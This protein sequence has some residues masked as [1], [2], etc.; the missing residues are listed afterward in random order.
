M[1]RL[2]VLLW[3]MLAGL[4]LVSC[5]G[6]SV[7]SWTRAMSQ[8]NAGE[9]EKALARATKLV[10]A[11]I[12]HMDGALASNL[13]TSR[14]FDPER[15]AEDI[16]KLSRKIHDN[17]DLANSLAARGF[18]FCVIG[19]YNLGVA[20]FEQAMKA[21]EEPD[22]MMLEP[23]TSGTLHFC[24]AMALWQ[25][26]EKSQALSELESLTEKDEKCH[27]AWFY[28]GVIRDELGQRIDAI[29][30]IQYAT[31]LKSSPVYSNTFDYLMGKRTGEVP[32]CSFLIAFFS[33]REPLNRP[34]GYIWPLVQDTK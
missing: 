1:K 22:L 34:Y 2:N 24:H 6:D 33:N 25:K 11:R 29:G 23:L 5:G 14:Y 9:H 17:D 28:Q 13:T 7:S 32:Y 10:E 4:L 20:D 19:E 16:L 31:Y 15:A 18:L 27:Q 12:A 21:G 30:N 26:G 8:E 3:V